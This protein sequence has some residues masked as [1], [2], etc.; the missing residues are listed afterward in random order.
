MGKIGL[1]L[2]TTPLYNVGG[3]YQTFRTQLKHSYGITV[4]PQA[5]IP[6]SLVLSLI[7]TEN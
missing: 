3:T 7:A 6:P 4:K 5:H 2:T 1:S